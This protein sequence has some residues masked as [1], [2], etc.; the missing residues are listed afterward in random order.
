M[1]DQDAGDFE[2]TIT[3]LG[4]RGDDID[5]NQPIREFTGLTDWTL[6]KDPSFNEGPSGEAFGFNH[7]RHA[8]KVTFTLNIR[9][10]SPDLEAIHQLAETEAE[11]SINVEAAHNLDTYEVGQVIGLG[12]ERCLIQPGSISQGDGDAADVSF[13][14]LGI[15]PQ[16]R[17]KSE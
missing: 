12:A 7:Q 1:A 11:V 16:I 14:V 9:D 10:T 4:P 3:P 6:E 15:D 17:R 5:L 2:L 13:S 8:N